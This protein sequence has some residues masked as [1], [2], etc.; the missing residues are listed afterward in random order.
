MTT[1]ENL[2]FHEEIGSF[3]WQLLSDAAI[4]YST[5]TLLS[6]KAG[7]EKC[8]NSVSSCQLFYLIMFI[9]VHL[10]PDVKRG[11]GRKSRF[12]L[13]KFCQ[14][15][16]GH[17]RLSVR[18]GALMCLEACLEPLSSSSRQLSS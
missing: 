1:L 8:F 5:F 13:S 4:S 14:I 10:S 11:T 3:D 16:Q 7:H 15:R 18:W 6:D 17:I 12:C 9:T 2:Q